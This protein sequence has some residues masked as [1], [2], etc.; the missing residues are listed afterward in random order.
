[1]FCKWTGTWFHKSS[2]IAWIWVR[3]LQRCFRGIFEIFWTFLN[4]PKVFLQ[5]VRNFLTCIKNYWSLNHR[6]LNLISIIVLYI[7]LEAP[8]TRTQSFSSSLKSCLISKWFLQDAISIQ[9]ATLKH[10]MKSLICWTFRTVS[11]ILERNNVIYLLLFI[12]NPRNF[13]K[14]HTLSKGCWGIIKNIS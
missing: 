9:K 8:D 14:L 13:Y 10:K 11:F 7:S 4:G 1:M 2:S 3:T 12:K 5:S 6:F